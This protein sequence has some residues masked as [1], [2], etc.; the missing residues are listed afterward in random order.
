MLLVTAV[1]LRLIDC[2]AQSTDQTVMARSGSVLD[3][4]LM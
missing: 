1:Q 2:F 4:L 3:S